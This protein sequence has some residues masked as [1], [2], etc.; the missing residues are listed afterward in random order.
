MGAHSLEPGVLTLIPGH[1][2]TRKETLRGAVPL[3]HYFLRQRVRPGDYVVDATCGNGMD[4]L[5]LAQLVGE[6]GRVWGFDVQACALQATRKLLAEKGC[7]A[8]ATLIEAG[9]ERLAEYVP[10]GVTAAVFNLGYLPGGDNDLVTLP[11][12]SVAALEQAASLLKPGGVITIALYTGHPG[13]PEE[14]AAVEQ[15]G[16]GLPPRNFNVWCSRQLN[17]PSVAPYLVLVEKVG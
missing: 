15:W 5:L 16:A 4:T 14:A 9:H 7:L 3:S 17:R 6:G 12:N 10:E 1:S 13:G 11:G 8:R 2:R